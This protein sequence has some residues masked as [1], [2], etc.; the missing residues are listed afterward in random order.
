MSPRGNSLCLSTEVQKLQNIVLNEKYYCDYMGVAYEVLCEEL[1]M[2]YLKKKLSWKISGDIWNTTKMWDRIFKP[3]PELRIVV[4]W[5][6][7]S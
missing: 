1:V 2:A 7:N 5:K 3:V 4:C 6:L